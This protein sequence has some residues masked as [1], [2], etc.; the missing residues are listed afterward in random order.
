MLDLKN[1]RLDY[2]ELL[3]PHQNFR[4]DQAVATSYSVNLQAL[5]SI[6]VALIYRQ[7]L[8]GDFTASPA[9]ML[10]SIKQTSSR[11]TV[12]HQKGL[13]HVPHAFNWL[14]A[15]LETCLSPIQLPSPFQIFHP[16]VWVLRYVND[17]SEEVNYR[18]IILSR[19]LT[20][21]RNWDVA[22]WVDGKVGSRRWS[23]NKPMV[24][25]VSWLNAQEP[26][27]Q[28]KRFMDG[29]AKAWFKTPEPFDNF[30]FHPIGVPG[31]EDNP[32]DGP[33]GDK[34]AAISPFVSS[35]TVESLH[36]RAA[37]EFWFFGRSFE[38]GKLSGD[39]L[40]DSNLYCLPENVVDGER[41]LEED[42]AEEAQD[43]D[44][45]AKVFLFENEESTHWFLGSAN[46]TQA[47]SS[48]NVEFMMELKGDS[49][50]LRI[51]RLVKELVEE[52]LGVGPF[53]KFKPREGDVESEAEIQRKRE[54]RKFE[55]A[56]LKCSIAGK[57]YPAEKPH[58]FDLAVR[59][60]L[61]ALSEDY[62]F[63]LQIKPFSP[64]ATYKKVIPGESQKISFAD[65]PE[66]DLSSFLEISIQDKGEVLHC[67][68]LRIKITGLPSH[69]LD[70]IF[71]KLVDSSEKFFEYLHF[72]LAD[73]VRKEELLSGLKG[74]R[75][76]SDE[77]DENS[78]VW[79]LDQP[80]YEQLLVAASRTPQ[81]LKAI[82]EVIKQLESKPDN[83]DDKPIVPPEFLSFWE[84]FRNSQGWGDS[85]GAKSK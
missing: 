39:Y 31:Y 51:A 65:I 13:L 61:G 70:N 15:Y 57:V 11:V 29:L 10:E 5:L 2:G 62:G 18:V 80:I 78:L 64:N 30:Q 60:N 20:F 75:T 79:N 27:P 68:L 82:D 22:A 84:A 44:L 24:D 8:E 32:V 55:H 71:R 35:Q 23:Q 73:E 34:V 40:E 52:P 72:L 19:N 50:K 85:K 7:T 38:M 42:E 76:S 69:R 28:A 56:L 54:L 45:H 47:A 43:Q 6:P 49:P 21:D 66:V 74:G 25:F 17:H 48:G 53:T 37:R 26:F 1:N 81:K 9:K 16:K 46:A 3:S 77:L 58:H 14:Y 36:D 41:I 83:E 63:T 67:F 33:T 12:Y 59:L 4:L